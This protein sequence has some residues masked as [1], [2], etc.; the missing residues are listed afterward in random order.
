LNRLRDCNAD[1]KRCEPIG[2]ASPFAARFT[3]RLKN[4]RDLVSSKDETGGTPLYLAV[5]NNHKDVVEL[6]LASNAD[7]NAKAF[8]GQT[9]RTE[10]H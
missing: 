9:Q 5:A 6:L 10:S 2:T 1:F 4:H 3:T 8:L 7:V